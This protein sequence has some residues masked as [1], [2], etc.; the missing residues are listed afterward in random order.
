MIK[1]L[2]R[3]NRVLLWLVLPFLAGCFL[4]AI[5]WSVPGF[6]SPLSFTIEVEGKATADF[7]SLL[8]LPFLALLLSTS[9]LGYRMMPLLAL[10]RGYLM[11]AS[12]A[13]LLISGASRSTVLLSIG[14]P[15]LFSVPAF[16]LV[17]EASA[18]SSRV[19]SLCSKSSLIRSCDGIGAARLLISACLLTASA[20]VQIYILPLI[21]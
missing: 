7:C 1:H 21:V 9:T 10:L 16:F 5:I 6:I 17:C 15:A 2:Q 4:G 14:L 20:A 3:I 8:W 13:L 12:A 19:I 18:A 11:S